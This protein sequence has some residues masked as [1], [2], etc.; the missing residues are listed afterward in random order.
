MSA[1]NIQTPFLLVHA[2]KKIRKAHT[3]IHSSRD[4]AND[5]ISCYIKFHLIL[6]L[7]ISFLG[8]FKLF[9]F[10]KETWQLLLNLWYYKYKEDMLFLY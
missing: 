1:R 8:Q 4:T 6:S 7:F 9:L 10:R 3:C 2:Q 5:T